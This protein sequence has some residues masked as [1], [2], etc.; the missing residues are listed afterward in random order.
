ME[1]Q[2]PFLP[3]AFEIIPRLLLLL[4]DP[5]V[6]SE[7]LAD[8]IRVDPGLTADL[9]QTANSAYAAGGVRVETLRDALVR[10]GLREVYR[11]VMKIVASPVLMGSENKLLHRLDLW[12][13][14][15]ATAIGAQLLARQSDIE[16]TEVAFTAGLLH[17]LGKVMLA[18]QFGDDYAKV[19]EHLNTDGPSALVLMEQAAFQTNHAAVGA[20][21]LQSWNFPE[22]ILNSIRYHHEPHRAPHPEQAALIYAANVVAY[23]IDE[24]YGYPPYATDPDPATLQSIK[25]DFEKLQEF[26][27]TVRAGLEKERA[28]FR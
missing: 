14:S 25:M 2:T 15:L 11:I 16:D 10:L 26:E 9:L 18:H 27:G 20:S 19:V 28:R 4:D 22:T 1:I 13:H 23:R 7:E 21:L 24:G 8:V 3:P 6:N 17:D 5:D 12:K